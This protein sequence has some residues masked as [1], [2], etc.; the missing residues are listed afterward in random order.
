MYDGEKWNMKLQYETINMIVQ[1]NA[2][3]I[4]DIIEKWYDKKHRFLF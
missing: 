1:D 4:E 2:N 3:L